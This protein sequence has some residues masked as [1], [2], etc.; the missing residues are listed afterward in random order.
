VIINNGDKQ[1]ILYFDGVNLHANYDREHQFS[2]CT[3][4]ISATA[5]G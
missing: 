2:P 1:V 3:Q 4:P 5:C